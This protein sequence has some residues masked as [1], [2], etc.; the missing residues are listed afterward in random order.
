MKWYASYTDLVVIVLAALAVILTALAIFIAILA[1]WGYR[2]MQSA[3]ENKTQKVARKS[4]DLSLKEGGQLNTMVRE[5]LGREGDLLKS[6]REEVYAGVVQ[7]ESSGIED[8]E[9]SDD[10]EEEEA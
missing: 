8:P 6:L 7:W 5:A 4:F 10:G 2:S 3:I 9:E 1:I